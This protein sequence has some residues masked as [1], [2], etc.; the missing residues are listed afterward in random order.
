MKMHTF[1]D[2]SALLAACK[3]IK[4]DVSANGVSAF[5]V[6]YVHGGGTAYLAQRR[7][8]AIMLHSSRGGRDRKC[9]S[10]S[11]IA[12]VL[13]NPYEIIIGCENNS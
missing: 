10:A 5:Y 4:K 2:R 7:G 1:Q 3:T 12:N 13:C 11:D 8:D 9:R 6:H